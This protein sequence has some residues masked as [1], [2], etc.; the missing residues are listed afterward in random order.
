MFATGAVI[1][2]IPYTFLSGTTATI[3]SACASA[4]GLFAIGGAITLFTGKSVLWSGLRQVAFGL[5][6]AAVVYS[7]GHLIGAKLGH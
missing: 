4:V 2:V 7:I 6:A 1:P 3:V 5:V